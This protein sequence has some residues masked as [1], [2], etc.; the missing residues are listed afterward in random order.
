V[1]RGMFVC[2]LG[3][4]DK[5]RERGWEVEDGNGMGWDGMGMG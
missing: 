2:E 1:G 4:S 5:L 3:R